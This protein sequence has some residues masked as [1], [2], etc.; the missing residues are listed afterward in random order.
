[1]RNTRGMVGRQIVFKRRAGISYV[2]APPEIKEGRTPTANQL[3]RQA[4]FRRAVAY[5]RAAIFDDNLRQ[6]YSE[7][8][9]RRQSA[10][11][12]AFLDAYRAPEIY[13]IITSGYNGQVGNAV[14]VQAVDDF[15]VASVSLLIFDA[16]GVEVEQGAASLSTGG[17]FWTYTTT[18]TVVS[19]T[20]FTI[21]A[22]ARDLSG[23]ETSLDVNI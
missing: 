16:N 8:A 15:R 22:I 12:V 11:N 7:A 19:V 6:A 5:A 3:A 23:N 18:V 13:E 20:G 1:M 14:Q 2:A 9:T 10:Y 17:L 21:R 4:Q